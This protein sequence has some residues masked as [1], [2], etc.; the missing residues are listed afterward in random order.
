MVDAL[1]NKAM[2]PTGMLAKILSVD[3]LYNAK[4]MAYNFEVAQKT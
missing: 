1:P 4:M 3:V 2:P